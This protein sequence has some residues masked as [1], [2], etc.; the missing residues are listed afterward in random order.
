MVLWRGSALSA[1]AD[2]FASKIWPCRSRS[3]RRRLR[4]GSHLKGWR[5]RAR[6]GAAW[7]LLYFWRLPRTKRRL[8]GLKAALKTVRTKG[9]LMPPKHIL[10]APPA[11][12]KELDYGAGYRYDHDDPT[13]FQPRPFS[14]TACPDSPLSA[15]RTRFERE[16]SKR[17]AYWDRLRK[18][19]SSDHP[20]EPD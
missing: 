19:K 17:L 9:T 5:T 13:G 8:C 10:N 1:A 15:C 18:V 16:I 4:L 14:R 3:G 12:M 7:N 20:G 11:L 6:S 2:R